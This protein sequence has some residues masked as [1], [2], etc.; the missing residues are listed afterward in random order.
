MVRYNILKMKFSTPVHIGSGK[1]NY[2]FSSTDLHSD[3]LASALAAIRAQS[4]QTEDLER[5]LNSFVLSSAFPYMGNSFFLPA[6][7]GRLSIKVRGKEE[8]EY[9]KYLKKIHFI[10]T[11]VFCRLAQGETVE[12]DEKQLKGSYLVGSTEEQWSHPYK[13]QVSQR[14]EV[15]RNGQDTTPFFFDWRYFNK[16]AGLYCITGA[17]DQLFEELVRLFRQLGETGVGTDKNVGGGKFEIE[18]GTLELAEIGDAN[19]TL[20]LSL[21]VPTEEELKK[22]RLTDSRYT[23]ILRGGYMAGSDIETFR[24]LWKKSIYM[25]GCGSIF[26]VV[27]SL[28]GKVVDLRPDWNDKCLHPVYRTGKPFCLHIKVNDYE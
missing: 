20:L 15:P 11:S 17:T 4:G 2:D 14:V 16:D 27:Q 9:R 8:Y 6:P 1:D 5:F 12:I 28:K 18:T 22:L 26:P 13:N 3:T 10:E 7:V 25:F 19:T 23:L 21:Y 24:H